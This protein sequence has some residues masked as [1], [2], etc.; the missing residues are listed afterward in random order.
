MRPQDTDE[1]I[2][3]LSKKGTSICPILCQT[4]H[5]RKVACDVARGPRFDVFRTWPSSLDSWLPWLNTSWDEGVRNALALWREMQAQGFQGQSGVVSQWAQRRRVAEKANQSGLARTPSARVLARLL[6]T[7]RADLAKSAAI[8]IAA[9]KLNA[10]ELV[11]AGTTSLEDFQ[12]VIQSKQQPNW[13]N[14]SG[15]QNSAL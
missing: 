15:Q 1:A 13:K 3:E 2:K 6:T 10:P 7:A 5:S 12:S 9:I 4:G 8:L 11:V 14:G